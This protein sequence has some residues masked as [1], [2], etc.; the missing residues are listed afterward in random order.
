MSDAHDQAQDAPHEGPTKSPKQLIWIVVASFLVPIVAI[1]MLT[2][3]VGFGGR[4]GAGT[5]ALEPQAMAARIQ[6][7]GTLVIKVAGVL[8]ALRSGEE[9]F[10]AVCTACHT[11]GALGAPKFGDAEAWAPRIAKGYDALLVSALKGK[12]NMTAQGGGGYAD[13]EV[14]RAVVYMANKAG[15]KFSEPQAPAAASSAASAP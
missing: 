6:P 3:F 4:S 14:G 15:A 10:T 7:V 11:A 2:N 5:A 8:G 1:I 12:G 13:T 9:V